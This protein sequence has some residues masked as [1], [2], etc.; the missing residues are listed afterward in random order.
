MT[1]LIAGKM[2]VD[3]SASERLAVCF[4]HQRHFIRSFQCFLFQ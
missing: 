3:L 1:S 2:S 4:Y